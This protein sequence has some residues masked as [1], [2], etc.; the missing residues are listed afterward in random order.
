MH[1]SPPAKPYPLKFPQPSK[2]LSPSG[3]QVFNI[4]RETLHIQ[5]KRSDAQWDEGLER[6]SYP[7]ICIQQ[8]SAVVQANRQRL[9]CKIS[10][11]LGWPNSPVVIRLL[12]TVRWWQVSPRLAKKKKKKNPHWPFLCPYKAFSTVTGTLNKRSVS[13]LCCYVYY[14]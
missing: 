6:Q 3:N 1:L 11:A 5:L 10:K 7:L 4:L 8:C 14:C 2:I 12:L 9:G 13:V